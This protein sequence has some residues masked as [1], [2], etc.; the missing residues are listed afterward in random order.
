MAQNNS[1]AVMARRTDKRPPHP[2][3]A[4]FAAAGLDR[5]MLDDF[6]T[7]PWGGRAWC[8]HIVGPA[9]L[10]R[11]GDYDP[12]TAAAEKRNIS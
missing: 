12:P 10:E 11:P 2:L 5:M 9:A 6:P 8:E 4:E 1:T 7:P 3:A